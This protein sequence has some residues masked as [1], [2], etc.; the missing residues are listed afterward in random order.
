MFLTDFTYEVDDEMLAMFATS[1]IA[2][3]LRWLDEA[4]TF[5]WQMARPESRE[6]W[7]R[8]REWGRWQR[9]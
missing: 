5:S 2:Q 1:T 4:R 7:L 6:R 8:L 3:R 9:T